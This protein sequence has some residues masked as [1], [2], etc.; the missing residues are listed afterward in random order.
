MQAL[1]VRMPSWKAAAVA[2]AVVLLAG[3]AGFALLRELAKQPP[4]P[5]ASAAAAFTGGLA[6][7][8]AQGALTPAEEAFAAS[9][10]PIHSE[11]KLA[12]VRMIFAGIKYKTGH[13]DRDALKA[14]V[15]P[16]VQVFEGAA[17]RTRKLTPPASLAEEHGSYLRALALYAQATQ[18]MMR[19]TADGR[20]EH[21]INAQR[22]SEVASIELLKLSD[23]LWPGEYKPN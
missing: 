10:W 11:V 1:A 15:A 4:A 23:P 7:H 13:T 17:A 12:A 22:H 8:E 16:L 19:V 3:M 5:Q 20:D 9:L 21:L 6:M 2:A 18:E 14:S